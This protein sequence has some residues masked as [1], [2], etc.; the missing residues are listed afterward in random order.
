MEANAVF[1]LLAEPF[2][3][4]DRRDI[5]V[6]HRPSADPPWDETGPASV[7]AISSLIRRH[8]GRFSYGAEEPVI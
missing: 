7:M 1:I 3:L 4:D 5:L 8:R 2:G 6:H